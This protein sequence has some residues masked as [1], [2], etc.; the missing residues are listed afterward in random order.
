MLDAIGAEDRVAKCR[1]AFEPLLDHLEAVPDPDHSTIHD[2]GLAYIQFMD[3]LRRNEVRV[4]DLHLRALA[5]LVPSFPVPA[6]TRI[7]IT[8]SL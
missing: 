3:F 7:A 4:A 2:F 1:A 5:L 8:L 6:N